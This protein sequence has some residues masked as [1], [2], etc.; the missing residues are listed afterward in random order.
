MPV[1]T[2]GLLVFLLLVSF[3]G[4]SSTPERHVVVSPERGA[5]TIPLVSKK[6]LNKR[7]DFLTNLLRDKNLPFKDRE[8]ASNLLGA[9]KSLQKASQGELEEEEYRDTLNTFLHY[10]SLVDKNYFD[11]EMSGT[12][13]RSEALRLFA[14]E[15]DKIVDTYISGDFKGV[16]KRCLRL[17]AEFGPSALTPDIALLFALS[18]AEEGMLEQAINIGEGVIHS[19]D[20]MPDLLHLRARM[21]ELQLKAGKRE[22]ARFVY[23]RLTD[24]LDE[25]V[26][27]LKSLER[28]IKESPAPTSGPEKMSRQPEERPRE[29]YEAKR[30]DAEFHQHV[31]SL[32]QG[33]KFGEAMDLLV[34]KREE[35]QTGAEIE[36]LELEIQRVERAEEKYIEEKIASISLREETLEK[37]RTLLANEQLEQAISNLDELEAQEE[38]SREIREL[39]EQAVERLINRE[40]NKAAKLFLAARDTQDPIKKREYLQS[41]YEILNALVDKYPSSPLNEKLKDHITKVTEE[42]EKL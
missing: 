23:E 16:I 9:Y 41:S 13:E 4:C 38:D 36:A 29:P 33:H 32:I 15:R 5:E 24:I 28:K 31:D 17:K 8:I 18:L 10:L 7:I 2:K 27:I 12:H 40:R 22:K 25:Q 1:K 26:A 30:T 19:M 20:A 11:R 35:A 34:S 6:L 14:D 37:T 3:C 42:L 21:A 39:R